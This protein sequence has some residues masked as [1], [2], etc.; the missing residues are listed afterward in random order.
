MLDEPKYIAR[1][2]GTLESASTRIS[3]EKDNIRRFLGLSA[4]ETYAGE[5]VRCAQDETDA[6]S[7]G[8][9]MLDGY[10]C[11]GIDLSDHDLTEGTL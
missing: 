11:G 2:S 5:I 3:R 1:P 10:L 7:P 9:D 4:R 8:A 6:D